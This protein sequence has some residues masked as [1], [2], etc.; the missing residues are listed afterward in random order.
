MANDDRTRI[1]A[2]RTPESAAMQASV[3]RA[4]AITASINRLTYNDADQNWS[5]SN[6]NYMLGTF[7]VDNV[8]YEKFAAGL[9][10]KMGEK[11]PEKK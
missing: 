4:M 8:Q 10:Q 1:I 11:A 3:Q 7:T 5:W 2:R 6:S 9:A